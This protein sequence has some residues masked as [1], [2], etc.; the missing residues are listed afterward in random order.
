MSNEAKVT[1]SNLVLPSYTGQKKKKKERT[2]HLQLMLRKGINPSMEI[3]QNNETPTANDRS[4]TM[5]AM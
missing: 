2:L 4:P 3:S 5:R 1:N